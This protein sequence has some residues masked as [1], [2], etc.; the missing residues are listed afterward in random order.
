M[1]STFLVFGSC[2]SR[3]IF[4]SKVNKNYKQFFKICGDSQRTSLISLMQKP[5]SF[6]EN[7]INVYIDGQLENFRTKNVREDLNK[8]FL[9][10][11]KNQSADYLLMD[12]H[13]EIDA[14]ILELEDGTLITHNK[15]IQLTELYEHLEK[16]RIITMQNNT[17][18]YYKLFKENCDEFFNYLQKHRPDLKVILNMTR[19]VPNIIKKNGDIEVLYAPFIKPSQRHNKHRCIL[20]EYI[21]KNY[22][23]DILPF[24]E[25]T[26]SL[27]NHWGGFHPSHF[28]LS[29]LEDKTK[30]LNEIIR[31]DQLLN[32][33]KE[34]E[35]INKKLRYLHRNLIIAK[36]NNVS[37]PN[38][39]YEINN[40][41]GEL[42]FY[43]EGIKSNK[44][45]N[46]VLFND[47][48]VENTIYGTKVFSNKEKEG[49]Y[50]IKHELNKNSNFALTFKWIKGQ[51]TTPIIQIRGV[52]DMQTLT[53]F[54]RTPKNF[55]QI[56]TEGENSEKIVDFPTLK[57]FNTY[58]VTSNDNITLIKKENNI[59]VYCD[60]YLVIDYNLNFHSN[61][62]IGFGGH[63]LG[64]RFT[65]FRDLYLKLL[66]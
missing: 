27:E 15:D 18:E 39:R 58:N 36:N 42:I 8:N 19:W 38:R 10:I 47:I 13:F 14:G 55:W 60:D 4:Y 16:K 35:N 32:S 11:L 52:S 48:C 64:G 23:V 28:E 43:D 1:V 49:F 24:D 46:W 51:F 17:L 12:T 62:Y 34:L 53:S 63:S 20:D 7:Q 21:C 59:K 5:F 31:K 6:N 33:S 66:Y 65:I 54:Q 25:S 26:L 37:E 61:F 44:N 30:Q 9:N 29:Y 3:D 56:Y 41:Y 40:S 22:D 57:Q 50:Y 2:N 45:T